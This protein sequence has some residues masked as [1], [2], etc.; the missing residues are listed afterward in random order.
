MLPATARPRSI[1]CKAPR[2]R[3]PRPKPH[4]KTPTTRGPSIEARYANDEAYVAA[5][6]REAARAVAERLLLEEDA[7]R[8]VEAAKQGTLAKLGQ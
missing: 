6:K 2:C 3:S 5:V 4:G 1:R 7:T 8:S